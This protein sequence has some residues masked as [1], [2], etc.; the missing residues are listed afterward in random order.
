MEVAFVT[1]NV[2]KCAHEECKSI[3][4]VSSNMSLGFHLQS[5]SAMS[6]FIPCIRVFTASG[7]RGQHNNSCTYVWGIFQAEFSCICKFYPL[8]SY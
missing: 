2:L 3:S 1:G 5:S 6:E 4:A 7:R 8:I